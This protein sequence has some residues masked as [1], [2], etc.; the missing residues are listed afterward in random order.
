VNELQN[1]R[2]EYSDSGYIRFNARN[3]KHDD[4]V[5]ALA[6]ALWRAHGDGE[7]SFANWVE[8]MRRNAHGVAVAAAKSK[9]PLMKLQRPPSSNVS[10]VITIKSRDISVPE[11]GVI[12]LDEEEARPMLAI[13][14]TPVEA[15]A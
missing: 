4:L 3:G 13:G 10:T 8:Y 9:L 12:E 5:L 1:F 11:S 15:A 6:I 7:A 14:W 2:A